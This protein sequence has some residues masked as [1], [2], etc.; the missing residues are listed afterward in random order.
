M[1]RTIASTGL[2]SFMLLGNVLGIASSSVFAQTGRKQE[3]KKAPPKGRNET[4]SMTGCIDQ[5]DGRYVLIDD[6]N[7]EPIAN[8]EAEG[9]ETEG[10]AKHVG[11]KVTIR[12]ISSPGGARPTFRVRAIETVSE[13][14]VAP[15]GH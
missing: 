14:C 15:G 9:F 2:L 12:G 6:R 8:L 13:S 1:Y 10:F 11:H 7:R 5:L 3:E 4:A